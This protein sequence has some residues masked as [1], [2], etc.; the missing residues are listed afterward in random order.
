[1]GTPI[2]VT[3]VQKLC[4]YADLALFATICTKLTLKIVEPNE[5]IS[6][7]PDATHNPRITKNP[8]HALEIPHYTGNNEAYQNQP[9]S[10]LG[11]CFVVV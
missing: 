9:N 2:G 5:S 1:M 11:V 10:C 6:R 7:L 3:L 8:D 4:F